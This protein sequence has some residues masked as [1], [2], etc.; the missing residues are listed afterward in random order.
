MR[1]VIRIMNVVIGISVE[2]AADNVYGVFE[3]VG[4]S[5]AKAV[6]YAWRK[7]RK[8]LDMKAQPGDAQRL[9]SVTEEL[10]KEY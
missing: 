4:S 10:L 7:Q 3:Q 6:T 9:W 5:G 1:T 8:P 2:K